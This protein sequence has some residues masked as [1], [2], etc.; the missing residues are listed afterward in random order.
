MAMGTDAP[1]IEAVLD[2]TGVPHERQA[3]LGPLTWYGLGG[4]A[5]ILAHPRNVGEVQTIVRRCC[6]TGAP[7]YVLGKGANLLVADQGVQG[8]VMTLDSEELRDYRIDGASGR[9]I[10]GGGADLEK[11]ITA[12]VRQ[13]LAGLEGL[14]GIPATIGGAIRMNA[15]GAFGQIG[16]WV[17]SVSVVTETGELATMDRTQLQFDYRRS[18]LGANILVRAEFQLKISDDPAATRA[19]L[20]EVMAYKKNSQPMAAHSAGCAYKNPSREISVK[21]AGQLIDEAGLKGLRV[22]GAEVSP[23]HGNFIVAHEQAKAADVLAVMRQ[24]ERTVAERFGVKL[25]REV[26]V[27]GEES[28]E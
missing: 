25:E 14:A 10:A 13:G 20:K 15:G 6:A 22:G 7:L 23:R 2:G 24:V 5:A 8:V 4:A 26:V 21:G 1:V 19:K 12:S 11:V 18:N 16:D 3:M 28:G 9:I 27:W 17:R